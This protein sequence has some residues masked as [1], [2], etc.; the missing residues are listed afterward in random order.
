MK[1]EEVSLSR[2]DGRNCGNVAMWGMAA[3]MTT[4]LSDCPQTAVREAPAA[5]GVSETGRRRSRF[6]EGKRHSLNT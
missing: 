4:K 3:R 5:D 2:A 1:G 6:R